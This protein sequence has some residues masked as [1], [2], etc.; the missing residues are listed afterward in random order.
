MQMT[1]QEELELDLKT[2]IT[3]KYGELKMREGIITKIHPPQS[4]ING[5]IFKR[6]EFEMDDGSWAKTDICPDF[7]NAVRWQQALDK[8]EGT[9]VKNLEMRDT[10]TINADSNIVY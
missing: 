3:Q 6:I 2:H 10:T 1:H 5:K 4:S 9:L 7:R 8:G